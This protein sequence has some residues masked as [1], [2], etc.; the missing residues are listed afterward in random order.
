M[1]SP[2]PNID[3]ILTNLAFGMGGDSNLFVSEQVDL[4]KAQLL[5]AISSVKPESKKELWCQGCDK[6]EENGF[7][8]GLDQYQ[9]AIE[10]LFKEQP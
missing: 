3:E 9:Q 8:T 10:K 1:T 7:N 4:A 2:Q 6:S 5:E